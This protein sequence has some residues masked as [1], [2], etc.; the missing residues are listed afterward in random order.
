M[1]RTRYKTLLKRSI[2]ATAVS[3]ELEG[4]PYTLLVIESPVLIMHKS[5]RHRSDSEI[6][7]TQSICFDSGAEIVH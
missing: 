4:W 3:I 1:Y 6:T 7:H 2:A 5:S